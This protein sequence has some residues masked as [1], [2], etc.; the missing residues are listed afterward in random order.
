ML[1]V[2]KLKAKKDIKGLI[3]ALNSRNN[4]VR[5]DAAKA[6]SSLAKKR[7]FDSTAILPLI[8]LLSDRHSHVRKH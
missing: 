5:G 2:D 4:T 6:I 3:S 8:G 1:T 7:I